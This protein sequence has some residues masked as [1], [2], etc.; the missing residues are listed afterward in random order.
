MRLFRTALLALTVLALGAAAWAAD[1]P[2]VV[3]SGHESWGKPEM[4]ASQAVL[5]GDPNKA[6]FYVVRL[7]VGPNWSFPA[8]FHPQRENVTVISGTLYAG[9]GDKLNRNAGMAYKA[10][11]FVSMPPNVRHYAYTKSDGA[12]IQ[13][14]GQGPEKDMMVKK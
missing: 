3:M 11:A 9:L 12:V 4:G 1:N 8:H 7:K 2:I 5:Y 14:D 10:G 6:G 13:I